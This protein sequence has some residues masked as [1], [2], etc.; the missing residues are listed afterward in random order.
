MI[1]AVV[2]ALFILVAVFAPLLA[3]Y[4]PLAQSFIQVNKLP[5]WEHWLG[6]DAFGRD[7]LSRMI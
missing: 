5:S 2:V 7:V 1:A 6:T 3:P 4:D